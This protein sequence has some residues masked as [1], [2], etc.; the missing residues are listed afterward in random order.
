MFLQLKANILVL[1]WAQLTIFFQK[2][3]FEKINNF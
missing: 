2:F 3:G 1:D